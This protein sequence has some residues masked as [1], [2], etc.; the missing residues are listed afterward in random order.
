ML[1]LNSEKNTVLRYQQ[2]QQH[3]L[4]PETIRSI[5]NVKYPRTCG[6]AVQCSHSARGSEIQFGPRFDT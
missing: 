2:Q 3:F 1:R 4:Q 6:W 5:Y